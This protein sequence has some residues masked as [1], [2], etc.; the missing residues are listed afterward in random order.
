MFSFNK[1]ILI[2]FKFGISYFDFV[3]RFIKYL[4][5]VWYRLNLDFLND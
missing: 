1:V 5:I 4:I 3:F 2:F